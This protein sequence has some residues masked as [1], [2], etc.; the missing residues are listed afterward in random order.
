MVILDQAARV[1]PLADRKRWL[2]FALEL[3][4]ASAILLGL[5]TYF[6]K[7]L[8]PETQREA[9]LEAIRLT[10]AEP[11]SGYPKKALSIGL[12]LADMGNRDAQVLAG[13]IL[14]YFDEDK[15][16]A[17]EQLR[18][19]E[20]AG[21]LY[22]CRRLTWQAQPT[23]VRKLAMC[24]DPLSQGIIGV[25]QIRRDQPDPVSGVAFLDAGVKNGDALA[26]RELGRLYG[27]G[28]HLPKD[29]AKA[30]ELLRY[31][32]D[33]GEAE[34]GFYLWTLS[35]AQRRPSNS[36]NKPQATDDIAACH[37]A[38]ELGDPGCQYVVAIAQGVGVGLPQDDVAAYMWLNLAAANADADADSWVG[39]SAPK[40][41]DR[42]RSLMNPTEIAEAQ[43]LTREWK[44]KTIDELQEPPLVR[45]I[46]E[47]R[48]EMDGKFP[49]VPQLPSQTIPPPVPAPPAAAKPERKLDLSAITAPLQKD[50]NPAMPNIARMEPVEKKPTPSTTPVDFISQSLCGKLI[51]DRAA[52]S[53]ETGSIQG[54]KKLQRGGRSTMT[55]DNTANDTAVLVKLYPN[56]LPNA[57]AVRVFTIRAKDSW[58]E[59]GIRAGTYELRY[60]DLASKAF[61]KTEPLTLNER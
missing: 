40:T 23:D 38:A 10:L 7:S 35:L 9:L 55:V 57:A 30:K 16:T 34:A 51:K 17:T 22:A 48:D 6:A 12:N 3:A 32:L 26:S 53:A 58:T 4:V 49:A 11:L 19:A 47:L 14:F 20:A 28:V 59:T 13:I 1:L 24:G 5:I 42:I 45:A 46:R 60:E 29:V 18:K 43:R 31:A 44:P 36:P 33:R 50:I 2:R 27:F 15:S 39:E 41:R 37:K 52:L 61:T 56:G 25:G 54:C 8:S 21:S